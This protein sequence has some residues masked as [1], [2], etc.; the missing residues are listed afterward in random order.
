MGVTQ[1]VV[2]VEDEEIS[3]P[4]QM[5]RLLSLA[6]EMSLAMS[7]APR[8]SVVAFTDHS[9]MASRIRTIWGE[10]GRIRRDH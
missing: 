9:S 2:V 1:A 6:T 3:G 8:I 7:R 10:E 5:G 4:R